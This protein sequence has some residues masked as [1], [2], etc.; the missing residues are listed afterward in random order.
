MNALYSGQIIEHLGSYLEIQMKLLVL[1]FQLKIGKSFYCPCKWLFHS[2]HHQLSSSTETSPLKRSSNT[3]VWQIKM[4][5]LNLS[6][7]NCQK[8]SYPCK[9]LFHSMHYQ[10][11]LVNQSSPIEALIKYQRFSHFIRW[12]LLEILLIRGNGSFVPCKVKKELVKLV[13]WS[14][15]FSI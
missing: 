2:M 8:F 15:W 12:K 11:E 13:K 5:V 9:W 10:L 4:L 6:G 3:K 7:E 14:C 1:I